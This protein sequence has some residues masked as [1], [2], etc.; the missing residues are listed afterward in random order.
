MTEENVK[1]NTKKK[2][3]MSRYTEKKKCRRTEEK[4]D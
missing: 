3:E 2:K 1:K 4:T